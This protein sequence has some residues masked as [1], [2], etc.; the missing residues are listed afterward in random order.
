[1]LPYIVITEN[2]QLPSYGVM[3]IIGFSL[4]VG[5]ALYVS[6][7][8]RVP[9]W[10]VV[11]AGVYAGL[12]LVVGAKLVYFITVLPTIIAD[13]E[14]YTE[15]LIRFVSSAFGGFV[16]YGGLIGSVLGII[17]YCKRYRMP[18]GPFLDV[19]TV[20][21]PVMHGIGRIGCF[22][23]GC[24]YGMEYD[25]PLSIVFPENE[26]IEGLSGVP[27]FPMQLVE[28]WYNLILFIVL[29]TLVKKRK[30]KNGRVFGLYLICYSVMR[31]ILEF[32]RGDAI[33]GH[34]NALST[35]QWIS[36]ILLPIGCYILFVKNNIFELQKEREDGEDDKK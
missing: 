29:F 14:F 26:L 31:F 36:L 17:I 25:G 3:A 23:A 1:M 18:V 32:F 12:G 7:I 27:R 35:S 19:A 13:W 2:L 15:D 10:D 30:L 28:A 8:V 16:F 20:A 5:V 4:A 9:E 21:I 34:F 11:F 33:R 22:L 6:R 24:C